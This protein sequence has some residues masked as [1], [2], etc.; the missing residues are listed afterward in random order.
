MTLISI[1][2]SPAAGNRPN[3][4][5]SIFVSHW[6]PVCLCGFTKPQKT[7]KCVLSLLFI[8][9]WYPCCSFTDYYSSMFLLWFACLW[10]CEKNTFFTASTQ[11]YSTHTHTYSLNALW[12]FA[13]LCFHLSLGLSTYRKCG[14]RMWSGKWQGMT[15]PSPCTRTHTQIHTH[16]ACIFPVL[17]QWYWG[18]IFL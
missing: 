18:A 5:K 17:S 15:L 1:L 13:P 6:D 3:Q 4:V 14:M 9:C 16:T 10:V 11:K 8:T 7:R 12:P 2:Y